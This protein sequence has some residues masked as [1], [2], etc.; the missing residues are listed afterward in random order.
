MTEKCEII[1]CKQ[2]IAIPGMISSH[3]HFY[4]Q[5]VRGMPVE[6]VCNW[7]QILS[8][9]WWKLDKKLTYEQIYYSTML[10]LIDGL[11]AGCT[12]FFDH[13]ASPNATD[14]CLD[15][16]EKAARQTG[17]RVCLSYEVSDRD[18]IDHRKSGINENVRFIKKIRAQEDD[19]V[20]AMFG[21]HASYTLEQ[22]TL[23]QCAGLGED[24]NVGFH[25]HV[26]EDKA[27]VSESYRRYDMHVVERLERAGILNGKALAAHC[28]N[29]GP[30]QWRI[31]RDTDTTVAYNAQSNTNNAV[32][33]CPAVRMMDDGVKVTL[34]GDGYTYDLLKELGFAIIT[35]KNLENDPSV[36]SAKQIRDLVYGDIGSFSE[37]IF[38]QKLGRLE[39]NA[40]ADFLIVDYK[41]PT[42]INGENIFAHMIAGF[43]G[44]VKTVI[45]AGREVVKDGK[46]VGIDEERLLAKCREQAE[47][48]W[49]CMGNVK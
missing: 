42:P 34:G 41:E 30:K 14:G 15:I 22:E 24:L 46:C 16:I 10:G 35:Q 2:E 21:L 31:L 18:G 4:G 1:N 49:R 37:W 33:I 11:K 39:V 36:F 27:D 3:S 6:P 38:G 20:K 23:E 17:A 26:A 5:F 29:I 8:R 40:A 25:I 12:T 45:I 48:L 28:V 19:M 7:Q 32:G 47:L 43:S 9:I 44:H 13:H